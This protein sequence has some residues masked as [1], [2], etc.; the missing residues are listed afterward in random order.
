AQIIVQMK[1]KHDT[2]HVLGPLQKELSARIAGATV[3]VRQLETGGGVGI[4]V[5]IRISGEDIP[6]L[7]RLAAGM[8][9]ILRSQEYARR[10]RDDWGAE[11][12]AVGLKIDPDKANMSG[13]TN[14]DVAGTSPP[15]LHADRGGTLREGR[16]PIPG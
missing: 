6:T 16:D 9:D 12:F 5:S 4:P 7:R 8:R 13:A 1:D 14:L 3:D 11:S 2:S 10:V 15:A